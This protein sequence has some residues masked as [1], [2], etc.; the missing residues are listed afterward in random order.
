M[1]LLVFL[2]G[3]GASRGRP[4]TSTADADG[5][6]VVRDRC[7]DVGANHATPGDADGCLDPDADGDRD[8]DGVRGRSDECPSLP[9]PSS[10]NGCPSRDA[11]GSG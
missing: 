11:D 1:L 4:A 10:S 2:L 5:D 9:A 7:A 3:C 6:G 8:G